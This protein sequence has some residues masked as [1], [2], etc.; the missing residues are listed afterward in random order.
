MAWIIPF[1]VCVSTLGNQNGACL[2]R[3]R[4]PFVAARKG[5][6]PKIFSMIHVKYYTPV[7]SLILNAFFGIIFILCG[8]VQFLIN[9]FGFVTWTVYGLSAAS[10]IILRYKKP[11]MTRPYRVPILIPILT[12]LLATTFVILPVIEKPN[13]FYFL[14]IGFYILSGISYYIFMVKK[15]SLPGIQ[16]VTLLLQKTLLVAETDW[17]VTNG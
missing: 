6:L 11:N 10:V 17:H 15:I 8:D 9:G 5:Y 3:G 13:I 4:L 1:T 2:L 14:A 16:T 7:P 12:C